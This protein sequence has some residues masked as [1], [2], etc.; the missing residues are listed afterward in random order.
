MSI[1]VA[2]GMA[3]CRFTNENRKG[4]EDTITGYWMHQ[5]F[6]SVVAVDLPFGLVHYHHVNNKEERAV[7]HPTNNLCTRGSGSDG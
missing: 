3:N 7:A 4:S 2:K 6:P 5:C 1:D